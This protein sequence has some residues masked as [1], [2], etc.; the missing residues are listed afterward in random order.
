MADDAP[1]T[2]T[3]ADRVPGVV[4]RQMAL[5]RVAVEPRQRL[6]LHGPARHVG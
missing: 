4:K 1:E 3:V 5:D 2:G 6:A